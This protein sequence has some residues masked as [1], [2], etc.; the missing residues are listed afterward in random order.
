MDW[1][2]LMLLPFFFSV[3]VAMRTEIRF[4]LWLWACNWLVKCLKMEKKLNV[5]WAPL[6]CTVKWLALYSSGNSMSWLNS[7]FSLFSSISNGF[8]YCKSC[9]DSYLINL[10]PSNRM[11]SSALSLPL[12]MCCL[13]LLTFDARRFGQFILNRYE[14]ILIRIDKRVAKIQ[15]SKSNGK[16][17]NP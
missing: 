2:F 4:S 6:L 15:F 8:V 16:R 10:C 11:I 14:S 17:K 7:L 1:T 3:L 5:H 9:K 12:W 13:L